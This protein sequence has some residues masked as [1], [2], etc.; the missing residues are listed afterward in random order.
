MNRLVITAWIAV[1]SA[2]CATY[3]TTPRIPETVAALPALQG[4]LEFEGSREFLPAMLTQLSPAG[5]GLSLVFR[6]RYDAKAGDVD[7]SILALFNPLVLVGFPTG[8][9]SV[10]A[11]AKLEVLADGQVVKEYVAR[12]EGSRLRTIYTGDHGA[13][14]RRNALTET[15]RSIDAQIALDHATLVH[16]GNS[17]TGSATKS[18][19]GDE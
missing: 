14:L 3:A 4:Q 16:L 6:Y 8:S 18:N 19:G 15:A 13:V 5:P 9:A 2:G 12:T 10:T 7:L 1:F 11:T 17:R